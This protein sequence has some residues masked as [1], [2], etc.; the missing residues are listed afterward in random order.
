[1]SDVSKTFDVLGW[2]A[3]S[4]L[5]MKILY[6]KLWLLKTGWDGEVPPDLVEIHS[7]W[8]DQLSLLTQKQLPRCYFRVDSTPLT[9]E[10]H[11]FAD[12]S[13]K[14]YGAVVYIR[15][16]Y[17]H[18]PP[19]LSLV[20]SKTRVAKL[21]PTTIPRQ[22]LC[23]AVLLTQL[24]DT[25]KTAL[26]I[27]DEDVHAWTDSSIVLSWL[28]GHP[29]DFK[30]FV[31]NR[32]SFLLQAT[33]PQTW[34][35][36][37]TAEN[38]ADCAS[39]GL[40]PKDLLLHDLWWDGPSWLLD[41]PISVPWQ[42]PR[43]PLSTPEQKVISCNVLQSA[44]PPLVETRYSSYHKLISITAWCLRFYHRLKKTHPPDPGTNGRH[45]SAQELT[46]AEHLL[47]RLSQ[48]RSF[49]KERHALLHGH[50]ISPS[51]RLLSLSPFL[52]QEQLLRVGERLSNSS[53]TLSQRYPV[54][55][56]SRDPLMI[57]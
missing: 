24:L 46:Q 15:S 22:E 49:P 57:L 53:L 11:G 34:R 40:M 13:V 2:I 55:T 32:V 54:I 9:T 35:H 48:A 7:K 50:S 3:P 5:V 47:A 17:L 4:V 33:S 1:M 29:R 18:H 8:R 31:S 36:V 44:P 10:L 25:V 41:D 14:G 30:T 6:Q 52:D 19:M 12:A 37:P 27:P 38:P 28:D 16:T 56:D 51:S 45:L 42:P 21:K 23:G 26:S 43:K 20:L 39:R